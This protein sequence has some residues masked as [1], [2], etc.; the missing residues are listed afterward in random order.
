MTENSAAKRAIAGSAIGLFSPWETL[1]IDTGSTTLYFAERL[2]E[3]SDITIV[4]N[5]T[6]IARVVGSPAVAIVSFSSAANTAQTTDRQS[7]LAIAVVAPLRYPTVGARSPL[8][9]DGFQHRR[10]AGGEGA[11]MIAQAEKLTVLADSSST[12]ASRPSRCAAFGG[13]P[14]GERGAA[15]GIPPST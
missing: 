1:F 3:L 15:E 8:R 7:P 9:P 10:S 11:P 6:E 4:T 12:I 2:A 5:S 13:R 14:S